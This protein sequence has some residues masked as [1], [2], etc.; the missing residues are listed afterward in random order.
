LQKKN[1]YSLLFRKLS[2]YRFHNY[3]TRVFNVMYTA[4]SIKRLDI[5]LIG[6]AISYEI[7]NLRKQNA[8]FIK[9]VS[10]V[11]NLLFDYFSDDLGIIG[12][13]AIFK[14]RLTLYNRETR[15]TS[16]RSVRLGRIHKARLVNFVLYYTKET[17]GRFGSIHI[18]L[19]FSFQKPLVLK[20]P[21]TVM[22][23]HNVE[24]GRVLE[25][26]HIKN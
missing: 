12:L 17:S 14:G 6:N 24:D 4:F 16:K 25:N 21:Q 15:R 5:D 13:A 8:L 2:L 10:Y 23:F 20:Y 19:V 26:I 22:L 9:F 1:Q 11:L 3:C 7:K 18:S